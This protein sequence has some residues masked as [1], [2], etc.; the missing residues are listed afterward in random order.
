MKTSLSLWALVSPGKFFGCR[1]LR[2][3]RP[4]GE[5]LHDGARE[6]QLKGKVA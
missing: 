1:Q 5:E 3:L 2:C 4:T 6:V